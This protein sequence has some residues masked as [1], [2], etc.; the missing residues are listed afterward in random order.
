[1]KLGDTQYVAIEAADS[2]ADAFARRVSLTP[3]A[4][5]YREYDASI[6]SWRFRKW[7]EV[8]RVV[9]RVRGTRRTAISTRRAVRG[10]PTRGAR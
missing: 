10:A 9:E 3:G 5:A 8:A 1:V 4:F 6:Q 7:S 2:I